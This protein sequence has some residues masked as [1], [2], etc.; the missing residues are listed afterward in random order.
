MPEDT[1]EADLATTLEK[2]LSRQP[3]VGIGL[4]VVRSGAPLVFRAH[5]VADVT[6]S[7]PITQD[8]IFRIASITKTFTAIA[9]MQLY[10]Q[11][12]V[13]LDKPANA[14]LRA[15][16]LMATDPAFRPATLRH[17]L[18]HTAGL[19][20]IA[21]TDGIFKPDFGESFEAGRPLPSLADFYGG[22]LPVTADPG[23]RFVYNNHGPAT[24]G[25]IVEDVTGI[26]LDRYLHDHIFAPLGMTSS[27]LLRSDE[28]KAR[29]ASGY[30]IR[31]RGVE[32]V[33]ERDMVTAGAASIYSTPSDMARY[34]TALLGGGSNDSGTILDPATLAM[35]FEPQWQP[36]PRLAGVGL[37]FFRAVLGGH[38]VVRHQGT[39]PGF[40]SEMALAPD[41]GVGVVAFTNGA[42]QPDFWLPAAVS[43]LL[44]DL[45][46]AGPGG[47]SAIP[48]RPELWDDICGWYRL[49]AGLTDVRLRGMLGVGAEVF[50]SRGR[51]MFRFL[52]PIP[53]L[54]RGFPLEPDDPHDPLVFRI[55]LPEEGLD[56]IRIIFG[57]DRN[58]KTTRLFL[59]L[60]PLVLDKQPASTNPKRRAVRSLA[61]LGAVA[62]AAAVGRRLIPGARV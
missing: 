11:G 49:D 28:V 41:D 19:P 48:K 1:A 59:D 62:G 3:V 26:T 5:G 55:D 8:T 6:A 53:S 35:M 43:G 51:L 24:L 16:R 47:Q 31:S 13:D 54:A 60:M 7:T 45:V 17:L 61:V 25:Q 27:N 22:A 44:R 57:Q 39:H 18:S 56:P 36:D 21:H 12:L 38:L 15:Y 30:E 34:A 2:V 14:Y 9:I 4:V 20:E 37:G 10:E 50:V 40:H 29:L 46:G 58:R 42:H 23:T 52:T 32:R 33:G